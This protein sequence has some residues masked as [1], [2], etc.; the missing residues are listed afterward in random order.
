MTV[1]RVARHDLVA[2]IAVP[3]TVDFPSP[4][5]ARRERGAWTLSVEGLDLR[6]SNLGKVFWAQEGYTKA[7]LLAYYDNVAE[8]ALRYLRGRALTLKRMPDGADGAFFY[9]KQAPAYTPQWVPTAAVRSRDT[10]KV[11]NYLLAENRASLLWI[12]NLGCIELHPWHSRVDDLGR[13]DY[14]FFDL[15]PFGV[16]FPTVREVA[17]LVRA[18][19][20]RLGLR[21]YPRTSGATGMQVYVP[22]KRVH[23]FGQVRDW[24]GRVCR[25]INRADPGRTTMEWD[26]SKR[27]GRVFL[28]HGMNTEGKNIASTYSLRPERGAPVA[29]PLTWEEVDTDVDPR[30]FTIASIWPRLEAVGDL[31]APVLAGDQD[32]FE[33]MAALGMDP[34]AEPEPA[35]HELVRRPTPSEAPPPE[36]AVQPV[37]SPGRPGDLNPPTPPGR[38][39]GLN[40][41]TPP[42]RPGGLNPPTPPGLATYARKRDFART[43]EPAPGASEETPRAPA[44]DEDGRPRF[45]IQH[46]LATRLHHDLR[47]ERG[48]SAPS[49]AVPKGLPDVP[50]LRHLAVQTEDHPLSYLDFSGDIPEG[51]YGA[52]PVRIW[53]RGTYEALEWRD[54]KLT[55]HLHGHRHHGVWHLFRTAGREGHDWMVVRRD[56]PADL[57]P[58]PPD[59][60]PMLAGDAEE[61]FDDPAWLFEVKWDGVRTIVTTV[62]PGAGPPGGTRLVSR[63]GA[64][65]SAG[66]PEL[67]AL[68]ERVLARNAV[69]DGEIVVLG[70][71]GRPSFQRLQQRMHLR[72]ARAVQRARQRT[73]AVLMVFDLLAVDGESLVHLPLRERLAQLDVTLVPGG[74]VQR[75]AVVA[76]SGR[77]LYDAVIERGLEGIIGKRADS[78]YR[79]GRRS[80]DWL[81]VKVRHRLCCVIGGWL[82]GEG[83]RTS[84]FGA[85]LVGLYDGALRFAGRVGSGFDDAELTRLMAVLE[86]HG[87]V[88]GCPFAEVPREVARDARWVEPVLVC[89]VEYGE[90]TAG[91]RLRG[92]SYKGLRPDV[93]P[94][95]CVWDDLA[96]DDGGLQV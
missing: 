57:V 22:L 92:P 59:Y 1:N 21:G 76:E 38:P 78:P 17:L 12:I 3:T 80:R 96:V 70:P 50:G 54:D 9:A 2:M 47:F 49:W 66:Y 75:S 89:E 10:G 14:A 58:P 67:A 61:P 85:L 11:I 6:L 7:D 84:T 79:P 31:F 56:E 8:V 63:L 48:E 30:D 95:T 34:S 27:Q 37:E 5:Q 4:L 81:K 72:E 13:P 23:S 86:E 43:P 40:P 64:D 94:R 25:L 19:L 69:L 41:P 55:F 68:W 20:E 74:A 44:G 73:P 77:A 65:V 36:P 42:G 18:A 71:D 33:A 91:G 52:G 88:P 83:A 28:D 46:H 26:I 45:V 53:D 15:D 29:T 90:A 60:A 87:P 39:G 62:R 51:E 16:S 93:D 24:V 32:L 35:G 82:P